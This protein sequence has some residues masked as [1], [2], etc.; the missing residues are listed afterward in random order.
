MVTVR[1][2]RT[3]DEFI[4]CLK[5]ASIAN[6]GQQAGDW[7]H[8]AKE[9]Y[10]TPTKKELRCSD[11]RVYLQL[12]ICNLRMWKRICTARANVTSMTRLQFTP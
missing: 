8:S 11:R 6:C 12:V 4:E 3:V 2:C 10:F 7:I 9:I 5:D 1:R